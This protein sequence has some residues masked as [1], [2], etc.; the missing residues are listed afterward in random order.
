MPLL[1]IAE[2]KKVTAVITLEDATARQIDQY[3][4]MTKA[5]A[6]DVVQ[7]ALDH[8]FAKDVDFKKFREDH[9]GA[10]PKIPLRLKRPANAPA[11]S[12]DTPTNTKASTNGAR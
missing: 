1:K 6:D 3:A 5:S 8:V 7:A 12:A 10:K 4:A 9:D 11:A 2:S